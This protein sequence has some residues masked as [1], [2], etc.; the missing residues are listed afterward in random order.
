[1]N[2]DS[3]HNSLERASGIE[4]TQVDF[5]AADTQLRGIHFNPKRAHAPGVV[6]IPDVHGVSPLY[7]E[8]GA[9]LASAGYRT[10]VLDIYSREGKPSLPDMESVFAWIENL[11]DHRILSDIATAAG[12][13]A[14][15][16]APKVAVVGFCL[17][18]QYAIMS[19]CR[20]PE[21]AA[22]VSF[23]GMLSTPTK[24]PHRPE[25]P[26]DMIDDMRCPLLGLYGAEDALIP[27]EDLDRLEQACTEKGKALELHRYPGAGHAF[28]NRFRPESYREQAAADAWERTLA[29][30]EQKLS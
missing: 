16:G 9:K 24:T 10:L 11:P 12:Y 7:E 18:G 4:G 28:L 15:Q 22:A 27:E 13:I 29:F 14:A 20:I 30:L 2:N 6:L 19:G 26:L 8:L 23:Y 21:F 1:M 3:E 25:A 5:P 17:G